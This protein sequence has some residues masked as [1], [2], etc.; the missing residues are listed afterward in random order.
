MEM[1]SLIFVNQI[2]KRLK[3][4]HV[5]GHY[6]REIKPENPILGTGP[7]ANLVSLIDLGLASDHLLMEQRVKDQP[8]EYSQPSL[9]GIF[10]Y[11]SINGHLN[12]CSLV[13]LILRVQCRYIVNSTNLP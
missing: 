2:I 8:A 3:T 6:H 10:C 7:K 1:T 11:A 12:V 13:L 4:F 9:T 5:T